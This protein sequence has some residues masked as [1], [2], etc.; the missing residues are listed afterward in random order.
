MRPD[1]CKHK[2]SALC[3]KLTGSIEVARADP[4]DPEK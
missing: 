3:K 4:S 2:R 1:R